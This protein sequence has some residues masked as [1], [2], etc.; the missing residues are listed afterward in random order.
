M[1]QLASDTGKEVEVGR[2][3]RVVAVK[4]QELIHHK[5]LK[6]PH[7]RGIRVEEQWLES[8]LE[9]GLN[10]LM[11]PGTVQGGYMWVR[12]TNVDT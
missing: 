8:D 12:R 9:H 10:Q 1:Q 5:V 2:V 11:A 7:H 4:A 6:P 3:L